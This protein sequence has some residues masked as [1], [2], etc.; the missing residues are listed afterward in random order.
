MPRL[1]A[2]MRDVLP[3]GAEAVRDEAV[4]DYRVAVRSRLASVIGQRE[5][6]TGKAKFGIFGDGKEVPQV[7]LAR[8]LRHGDWRAGYYRD[9]TLVLATGIVTL[10]QFFAQ[11]YGD[12]D[13]SREPASGG[14]QMNNHFAT[15]LLDAEGAWLGQVDTF[16]SAAGFGAVAVQMASALG[17]AYASKLYREEPGLR[18]AAGGFSRAGDEVVFASIG[19]A[20][21]AEGLFWETVNAAAVLQVPMVLSVWDD[22]YGI[23]VPNELQMAK[24]SV[25]AALAGMA[26]QPG[27]PGLDI[28]DVPGWDYRALRGA[29][30]AAAERARRDHAPVLVHVTELTQPQGHS[31]SGSQQ[32]YKSSDRLE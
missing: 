32:R 23:S 28:H 27:R 7:A 21:A 30:A 10:K 1:Q 13:L 6:V 19:N 5:V 15:R 11:L 16:N 29:Y 22:G 4:A 26:A 8:E 20:S 18:A 14:R 24:S 25:S 17:L 31:T 3:A 9:Q 2:G 12:P